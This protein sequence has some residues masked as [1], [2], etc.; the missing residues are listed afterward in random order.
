MVGAIVLVDLVILVSWSLVDPIQLRLLDLAQSVGLV[1]I[2]VHVAWKTEFID[3]LKE[4]LQTLERSSVA[5][6]KVHV[7]PHLLYKVKRSVCMV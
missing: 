6:I 4:Y 2:A 3:A 1:T 7:L 5:V